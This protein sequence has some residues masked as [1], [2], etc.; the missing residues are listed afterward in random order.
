MLINAEHPKIKLSN[1]EHDYSHWFNEKSNSILCELSRISS[2]IEHLKKGETRE[3]YSF[4][5]EIEDHLASALINTVKMV[6]LV[7]GYDENFDDF[8]YSLI[9]RKGYVGYQ[10]LMQ[11]YG[12]PEQCFTHHDENIASM[13]KEEDNELRKR[14]QDSFL[15]DE[16]NFN[17]VLALIHQLH[18]K[19][20]TDKAMEH[21]LNLV[22]NGTLSWNAFI[23]KYKTS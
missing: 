5:D 9:L 23:Q 20:D 14:I 13:T 18:I 15:T 12:A 3:F 11:K 6:S 19:S 1:K 17:D 10:E 2:C 21:E 8:D 7:G 16:T 4:T 22:S